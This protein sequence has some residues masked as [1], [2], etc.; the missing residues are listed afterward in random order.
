MMAQE[1]SLALVMSGVVLTGNGRRDHTSGP[2][3]QG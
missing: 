3:A 1:E 2:G